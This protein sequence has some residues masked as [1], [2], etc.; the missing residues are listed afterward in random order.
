[1]TVACAVLLAGCAAVRDARSAQRQ[2]AAEGAV[3][4]ARPGVFEL[5]ELVDFALTN[6]PSMFVRRLA[7]D[8]AHLALKAIAADAPLVSD[9]PWWTAAILLNSAPCD[10]NEDSSHI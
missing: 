3:G 9:Q 6:R 2:C 1:M 10:F 7:V 4:N 5:P 8:D